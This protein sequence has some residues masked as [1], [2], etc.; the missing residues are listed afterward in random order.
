V[1]RGAP[2]LGEVGDPAEVREAEHE[3]QKQC[4]QRGH[5]GRES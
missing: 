3:G 5:V 4:N 1:R 2:V